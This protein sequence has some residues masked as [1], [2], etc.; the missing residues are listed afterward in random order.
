M[1]NEYSDQTDQPIQRQ[2][3]PP[4]PEQTDLVPLGTTY[5]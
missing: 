2:P 5:R 3:E 1:G 4:I